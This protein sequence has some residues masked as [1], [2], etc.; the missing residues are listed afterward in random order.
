MTHRRAVRPAGGAAGP[1][2]RPRSTHAR[3][4]HDLRANAL[5]VASHIVWPK[6]HSQVRSRSALE[7]VTMGRR[8]RNTETRLGVI[9]SPGFARGFSFACP[10]I[11]RESD[12]PRSTTAVPGH[13]LLLAAG[14]RVAIISF[15][16]AALSACTRLAVEPSACGHMRPAALLFAKLF[17][18]TIP[19]G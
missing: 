19:L 17:Q 6:S 18:Q 1:I 9:I 11:A 7:R 4:R 3:R 5:T 12:C 14:R 15:V 10:G 13:G 16:A 2:G 8:W